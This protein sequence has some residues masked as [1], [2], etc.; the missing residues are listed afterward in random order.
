[1]CEHDPVLV[2]SPSKPAECLSRLS[3]FSSRPPLTTEA[4]PSLPS[5]DLALLP[6]YSRLFLIALIHS[7]PAILRSPGKSLTKRG[8]AHYGRIA[9]MVPG[10]WHKIAEIDPADIADDGGI[11]TWT[12]KGTDPSMEGKKPGDCRARFYRVA[13][14]R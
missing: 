9:W 13:A 14:Y 4:Q 5:D 2:V 6:L 3:R 1:M 10:T 8:S 12:D 11:R 7:M